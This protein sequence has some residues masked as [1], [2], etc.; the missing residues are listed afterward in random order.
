MATTTRT[1]KGTLDR[2]QV[3]GGTEITYLGPTAA[4]NTGDLVRGFRIDP[5]GTSQD[6]IV[7]IDKS[8]ALIDIKIFQEDSF[9]AGS[10]PTGYFKYCNIA[11]AG[12]GKGAI[13]VTVTDASKNYIVLLTFDDYSEAS[14][15]GSVVVPTS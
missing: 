2:L 9:T 1:I 6:I 10:A 12:K 3:S 5:N 14:Y 8:S 11:K 7:K 15:I 13:G 4:N